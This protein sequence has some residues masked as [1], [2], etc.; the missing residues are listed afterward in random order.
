MSVSLGNLEVWLSLNTA[1]L[2]AGLAN[3]RNAMRAA[4]K[5]MSAVG[6]RMT[7]T[8]SLPL[9]LIG[10]AAIKMAM[11]FQKSL[12]KINTLVG[13]TTER[14]NAMAKSVM[15]LSNTTGESSKSLAD[16]LFVVTSAGQRGDEAL[17]ILERSA[18]AAAIGLG[19]AKDVARATTSIMNAY[20]KETMSATKIT[21]QLTAVV[22]EGN[23]EAS[24]LAP[25][26]GRVIGV[27]SN[28]GISF[29]QVGASIA[30]FTRLGV[31]SA[32]AV[33]GVRGIMNSLIKPSE[34]GAEALAQVGMSFRD[35]RKEVKE[36]G[37]AQSLIG[38]V[39]KFKGNEEA[40]AAIVPNVRAL[41][42]VLGTAGS[43]TKEY[44]NIL[45]SI[46][47]A[48]GLVDDGFA[49][50]AEDSGFK[51]ARTMEQIKN[52]G[53]EL[54]AMLLPVFND[55]LGMISRAAT[56]FG[57]LS[58]SWKKAILVFAGVVAAI[59]PALTVFGALGTAIAAI[60]SPIGLVVVGVL[61]LAAAIFYVYDNWQAIV[62]R[63]SD[64][65][66][67]KNM[68]IDMVNFFIEW[69]PF[70]LIV[71]GFNKLLEAV[72]MDT[73]TN[74]FEVLQTAL[75]TLK[76]DTVEY[77]HKFKDFGETVDS[78]TGKVKALF[79][80]AAG[81]LGG[82]TPGIGGATEKG[83]ADAAGAM[84]LGEI[85]PTGGLM[86][87]GLEM[88]DQMNVSLETLGLRLRDV[89]NGF[90]QMNENGLKP[91][92]DILNNVVSSA[93]DGL[94][95]AMISGLESGK[96]A[97]DAFKEFFMTWV[98][99][100][101]AKMITMIVTSLILAAAL[102]ALGFGAG[103]A[104]ALTSIKDAGGLMGSLKNM[105][106]GGGK[107]MIG[108]A[109]GGNVVSGGAFQLHKDEVV[110]LPMGAK[111]TPANI[112]QGGRRGGKLTAEMSGTMI[113]WILDE[114]NRKTENTY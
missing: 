77:N 101:I 18:K 24:E 75:S 27:A 34:Q 50:I 20:G 47:G 84:G 85:G 67:W 35:L 16:A 17:Q 42:A 79:G 112:A 74:P 9:A 46:E 7:T 5:Q 114:E 65:S 109:S 21:D 45:A 110:S 55:F 62:E 57:N 28:L 92:A 39:Q 15:A 60:T 71:E 36:K 78:I 70:N 41:S 37:L 82:G 12:R 19:E 69:N 52:Q 22:R 53:I 94:G 32:E 61:S 104:G 86:A 97:M 108:M 29:A 25:V 88:I 81:A 100:M 103:A 76:D 89:Q 8:I 93:F 43:Q 13:L 40:L 91:V 33:T 83:P 4:S 38:L 107:S 68:L 11:D 30:T 44:A 48:T 49:A 72:G 59:G 106:V 80:G 56:A 58:N 105:L 23:L 51:F 1:K 14:V 2:T 26:L 87:T 63:I 6:K 113:K 98:K 54:G 90:D 102:A 95:N 111:V 96:S 99:N 66:W 3:A 64:W 31:D 73:I 10:G